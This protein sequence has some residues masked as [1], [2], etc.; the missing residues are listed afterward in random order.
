MTVLPILAVGILMKLVAVLFVLV[1]IVLILVILIQKGRGGGLS[2]AFGGGMASG[3]LGSKTGD[4]LTWVT[5]VL[6]AVFLLLAVVLGKL[7]KPEISD[8]GTAPAAT[9]Q[10]AT[11]ESRTSTAAA[12]AAAQPTATPAASQGDAGASADANGAGL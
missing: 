3:L 6:V 11:G 12:P 2:A 7:Y 1:A 10:Q 4:F 5:I 8:Y 9:A